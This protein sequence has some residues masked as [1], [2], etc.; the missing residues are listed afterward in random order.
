MKDIADL[1]GRIILG[2]LF[3]YHAIDA[4]VLFDQNCQTLVEYGID[5][6][7]NILLCII[8][9]MLF[10]GAITILVGYAASFG[11][12]LLLL[13]WLPYTFIVFSFWDDP[14]ELKQNTSLQFLNNLAICGGLFLLIANG[15]GRYSVK[16]LIYVMKL[17][18]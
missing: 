14:F 8:I 10:L 7:N 17:P 6:Y 2:I 12:S 3:L 4:I 18:S 1:L 5:F 9:F 11:A 16:R 13:Y 15:A